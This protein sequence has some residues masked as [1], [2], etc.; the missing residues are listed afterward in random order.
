MFLIKKQV[1]GTTRCVSLHAMKYTSATVIYKIHFHFE[2][3]YA[4]LNTT[5]TR[6]NKCHTL[7][8]SFHIMFKERHSCSNS[9]RQCTCCPVCCPEVIGKSLPESVMDYSGVVRGKYKSIK[10][11]NRSHFYIMRLDNL[12]L[13]KWQFKKTNLG[14]AITISDGLKLA[15]H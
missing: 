4:Q 12:Y 10:I 7:K 2:W 5:L 9:I 15:T 6:T 11:Q 1:R 13:H 8:F 3:P 14:C